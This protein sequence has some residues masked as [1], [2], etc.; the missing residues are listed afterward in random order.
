ME[1]DATLNCNDQA[2]I[3]QSVETQVKPA[4]NYV[5]KRESDVNHDSWLVIGKL[6]AFKP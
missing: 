4:S 5:Q 6:V 1:L 3:S 2:N